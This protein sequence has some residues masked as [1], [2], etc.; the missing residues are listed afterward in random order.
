MYSSKE[1]LKLVA[2][3]T[4]IGEGVRLVKKLNKESIKSTG[5]TPELS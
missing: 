4:K 2:V 1:V 5:S 3:Q